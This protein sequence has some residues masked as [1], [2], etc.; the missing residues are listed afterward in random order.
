MCCS[1]LLSRQENEIY[2]VNCLIMINKGGT[3]HCNLLGGYLPY[4]AYSLS[5]AEKGAGLCGY[6]SY[7]V[8]FISTAEIC[9]GLKTTDIKIICFC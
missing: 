2:T 6:L 3:D 9:V 1:I 7:H 5:R 4:H 8:Y